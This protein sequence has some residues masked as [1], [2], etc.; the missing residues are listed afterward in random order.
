PFPKR[1]LESMSDRAE[2]LP[3][4]RSEPGRFVSANSAPAP[5]VLRRG[6][7]QLPCV[8]AAPRP[9]RA[10][11]DWP[12]NCRSGGKRTSRRTLRSEQR[13][14]CESDASA[15]RRDV[16]EKTSVRRG[17]LRRLPSLRLILLVAGWALQ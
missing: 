5:R 9:A 17:L 13:P 1:R 11:P 10:E 14:C 4:K 2:W 3:E 12:E 7:Q 15:T 8:A 16:R 6:R